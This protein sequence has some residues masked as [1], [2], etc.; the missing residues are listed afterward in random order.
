[1]GAAVHVGELAAAIRRL[2]HQVR[3]FTPR[4][5]TENEAPRPRKGRKSGC[6]RL[7]SQ[8]R[9]LLSNAPLF[10]EEWMNLR[11]FKPDA[12][13]IRY[14]Y[15]NFSSTL[16][17]RSLGVPV[18]LEVNAPMAYE[19]RLF[20]SGNLPCIPGLV[21]RFN[22]R[23]ATRVFVVSRQLKKYYVDRSIPEKKIAVIPNGVD[24]SRFHPNVDGKAMRVRLGLGGKIVLG[25]VGSFHYWH[26]IGNLI[27]FIL[28]VLDRFDNSAFL[29]VGRG[30][31]KEDLERRLSAFIA[32]GRVIMPGYM[33]HKEM[34]RVLAVMDI[35]LAP[36][37][38][39]PY[40]Y[41]SPL[42]LFE[43]MAAEKAVIASRV[44]QVEEIITHEKHGLLVE[45]DDPEDMIRA[46]DRL[47]RHSGKRSQM[48]RQARGLVKGRYTWK[49]TAGAVIGLIKSV[50]GIHGSDE[51]T[52]L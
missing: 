31:L 10:V 35:A 2:G 32:D 21:E 50:Q 6:R 40:F 34:P 20:T 3:V 49:I 8:A 18:I 30:P 52:D 19:K 43:Y 39:L 26:G 25:F 11:I 42:K 7:M 46:A 24:T 12:V 47:I 44:G 15:L 45:P 29:L 1:V 9:T 5:S 28:M 33:D 14:N 36:Y 38:N 16:A 27:H 13:L 23:L 4:R 51:G 37:P 22:I 17:A 48:G 41:Y